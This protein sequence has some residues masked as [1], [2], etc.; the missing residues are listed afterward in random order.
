[1]ETNIEYFRGQFYQEARE[2][3][4]KVN[5]DV[6]RAEAGPGDRELLNSI[7]RGIHTIKGSA[8]G[9]D[10][11]D[12]SEFSHHLES[13]LNALRDGK[14]ELDPELVDVILAGVDRIGH[15]IEDHA[16][17]REAFMDHELT[18][19]F[20]SFLTRTGETRGNAAGQAPGGV[21]SGQA[22]RLPG[23]VLPD[24]IADALRADGEGKLKAYR[25]EVRYTSEV[26]EHG[27]DPLV[28]LSNIKAS[29][30]AYH[31]TCSEDGIPPVDEF[32]PL[33]LY[34]HPTVLVAT[35]L[36]AEDIADM[37]FDPSL[38]SIEVVQGA[39]CA[40]EGPD[41]AASASARAA[42]ESRSRD[43]GPGP[44]IDSELLGEFLM[45]ASEM[46]ESL[47]KAV[48]E[49]EAAESGPSLN[50]VFR[51]V[52]NL[53]GD[54]DFI[55]LRALTAFAHDLE[56]MLDRLRSGALERSPE[57]VDIILHSV[58]HLR[59]C[60]SDL[61]N[62]RECD[63]DAPVLGRLKRV[64]DQGPGGVDDRQP[65]RSI[66]EDM[67]NVF[68]EQVLQYL[69]MLRDAAPALPGD[70]SARKGV[71][72]CLD[73]LS[74]AS[75][76]VGLK[77]LQQLTGQA[78]AALGGDDAARLADAME[79]LV[80]FLE[81][82]EDEPRRL[83]EILVREGKITTEDLEAGLARQKPL[84]RILVEEGKVSEDDVQRA[85]KKQDLMETARQLKP[86]VA[87]EP[88]V[89]TMR[90]D[91][92]KVEHF[93]N[94]MGELLIA[95]NTY[96][97]LLNQLRD[98]DGAE[99]ETVKSLKE[100]LH[101]LTRLSNDMHHGVMSLRMIPIRGI[102]QKFSR[103]VRDISRKQRKVVDLITDGE[104]VEIDKKVADMLSDPLVHLVRN[105]CDHGI[106]DAAERRAAGK[107]EKGTVLLRASQEGRNLTIRII[108]DGRG[109]DRQRLHEKAVSLGIDAESPD[110]PS[111]LDLIFLPG[112][113]T[114]TEVT[115]LSGRGV[116]MDVVKT[117]VISLGG[118]VQVSSEWGRG[119]EIT[120]SIPM[121]MGISAAL[122]VESGGKTYA[123]PLDGIVETL[124]IP[125]SRVRRAG[126]QSL[127][128]YRGEVLRAE[129][130][131]SLLSGVNRKQA[132]AKGGHGNGAEEICVVILKTEA[133]RCGV[134]VDRF[135]KNMEL[136]IKP[137]P[138]ALTGIEVIS[139][140]S[141]M[142]DGRI[143][144]VLNPEKLV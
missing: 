120:L 76:C 136:A 11:D 21:P 107:P 62:G 43:D 106:E 18:E 51:I 30:A 27:Y 102:F 87:A 46:L 121:A 123:L 17:G 98:L 31:V 82:F 48:I 95:R 12:V 132:L 15:M 68:V 8:G 104:E 35:E 60:L 10:L 128:Y 6:L 142:G 38:V 134:V 66:P 36:S 73:G 122:L 89:R 40:G 99:R 111:L 135:H 56:S 144:L 54:A 118:S 69:Q 65:P 37:T 140:V 77:T 92:R 97:Y 137:V 23:V 72:R 130:L 29:S 24:A 2:I 64:L 59:R 28:L 61:G 13:L 22:A 16:A 133:G 143:L 93:T 86:T 91:E 53:K 80:A 42:G 119:T 125:A 127:F 110:D 109:I 78:R 39:G 7:F 9:F 131:Q 90:I 139:G 100:N 115:D 71:G 70:A 26:M 57:V 85:L 34:L 58:D 47:E 116:G 112:V 63:G 19:R 74:R 1:M 84:G 83:G 32:E 45:G 141:I 41:R 96:E 4:E 67:E 14:L 138:E 108:D 81:G 88:E 101:L 114:K 50:E 5:E 126:S 113:S 79:A 117:T 129:S 44:C 55:G 3:L 94:I 52:H 75:D 124:K 20:K 103:V 49:Y 105:A 25:I 33:K